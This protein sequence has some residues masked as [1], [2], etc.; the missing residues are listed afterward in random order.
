LQYQ[1]K[2]CLALISLPPGEDP[3][4]HTWC[5]CCQVD[6]HHGASV[7]SAPE[8]E[9]ANHPGQP[10]WHPPTQPERPE[11]CTICRPILHLPTVGPLQLV[12]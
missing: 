1:C 6:H 8:C 7:L 5:D 12:V 10:C 3:H 11:G 9:A 4:A 2:Q